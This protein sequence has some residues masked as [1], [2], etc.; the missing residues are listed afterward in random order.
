MATEPQWRRQTTILKRQGEDPQERAF[1]VNPMRWGPISN[2]MASAETLA[3]PVGLARIRAPQQI[4]KRVTWREADLFIG[5]VYMRSFRFGYAIDVQP[6]NARQLCPQ[7]LE[8][9]ARTD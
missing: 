1:F 2:P 9:L 6:L 5:V 7:D 3:A 4:A 8:S